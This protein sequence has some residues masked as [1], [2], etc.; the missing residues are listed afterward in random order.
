MLLLESRPEMRLTLGSGAGEVELQVHIRDMSRV[1]FAEGGTES[2]AAPFLDRGSAGRGCRLDGGRGTGE[3]WVDDRRG[4]GESLSDFE[5]CNTLWG[6]ESIC[7]LRRCGKKIKLLSSRNTC[8]FLNCAEPF[9]FQLLTRSSSHFLL[10][11][12]F[13]FFSARN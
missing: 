8:G 9:D 5:E 6:G 7:P 13:F 11:R 12:V 10:S 3:R 2:M 4:S 1:E